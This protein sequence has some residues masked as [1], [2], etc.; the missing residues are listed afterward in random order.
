MNRMQDD[1]RAFVTSLL[2]RQRTWTERPI[3]FSL[4]SLLLGV[5]LLCILV[6]CSNAFIQTRPQEIPLACHVWLLVLWIALFVAMLISKNGRWHVIA[7]IVGVCLISPVLIAIYV[8]DLA[9]I[10]LITI[11]S[12]LFAFGMGAHLGGAVAGIV[13]D[14]ATLTSV[15]LTLFLISA[16]MA[17]ILLISSMRA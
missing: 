17:L 3:Q 1:D 16:V 10:P 11:W 8:N 6:W 5:V 9:D 13:E 15:H 2:R 14:R 7:G 4:R 12:L